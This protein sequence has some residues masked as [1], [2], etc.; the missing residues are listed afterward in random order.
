[1]SVTHPGPES[2]AV[3]TNQGSRPIADYGLLAD[4]NSAALV[5]RDGSIAWLC[6]PRYDSPGVFAQILD[7][8]G[9]HW[10]IKPSGPHRSERRY[11]PGTL[12]IE[13]TFAT[14]TGSVRLTDAMAFAAG[15][16]NHEL[17]LGV[18]HLLLRSIEGLVGEVELGLVLAP[19]PEYG[20]VKPLFRATEAGGRTFGGPNQVVVS[21][22]VKTTIED[23]TMSA[24]FTVA[25]GERV[26]FALQWAPPEG[27][28]P[29]PFAPDQVVARIDDTVEAW[30][31]WEAEHDVYEGPHR[32]LVR[33]SSRILKGLTYRP[34][35]A[36]VA[37]PTTS[38]P[39][40]VGGERNWD[41]RYA[42]IRD[43]TF[44]LWGL[45]TLGFD[46]EANDFF[47]FIRDVAANADETLQIMY[48]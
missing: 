46:E 44:M 13:T 35:G 41:Y 29:E 5:D 11:L 33:L 31:S 4:C 27:P 26:G 34:T 47:Y 28:A 16:R 20:L 32:E 6:L 39:E 38:L 21:A 36:I 3:A 37:A 8:E 22:G 15:Q 43:S 48:G 24:T 42:W 1:M 25:A 45:Y 30:R 17:G 19:R 12:V 18:P 14:E 40:T 2:Q 7:P 23:S 10:Q 9:G